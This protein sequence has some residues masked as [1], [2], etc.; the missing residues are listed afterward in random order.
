MPKSKHANKCK[1]TQE[2]NKFLRKIDLN[3]CDGVPIISARDNMHHSG[4]LLSYNHP[5]HILPK[6][7]ISPIPNP[8]P[9]LTYITKGI[10]ETPVWEKNYEAAWGCKTLVSSGKVPLRKFGTTFKTGKLGT[11]DLSVGTDF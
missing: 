7:F 6:G 10:H 5:T 3:F 2:Q 11:K 8:Y 4:K 9:Y 1:Q